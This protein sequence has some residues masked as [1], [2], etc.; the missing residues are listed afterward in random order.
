MIRVTV[1]LCFTLTLLCPVFCLAEGDGE[2]S[3][4][5]QADGDNCEAM[6]FGAVLEKTEA[7]AASADQ[8]LPSFD[9]PLTPESAAFGSY[10]RL[11]LSPRCR[12][13]S[14]LPSVAKRRRALLQT[15]LI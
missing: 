8:L 13:H 14:P 1:I 12:W 10:R 6:T 11:N 4:Y 2:C 3:P 7:G 9:G 5:A 15:F